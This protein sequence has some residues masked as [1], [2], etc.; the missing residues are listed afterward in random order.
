MTLEE[1]QRKHN[2]LRKHCEKKGI[3]FSLTLKEWI[4]AW[5]DK[6]AWRGMLQLRRKDK[7]LGFVVG[8]VEVGERPKKNEAA[9]P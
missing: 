1:A 4:D 6:I 3:P 5:G 8:N 9:K 2:N 7:L